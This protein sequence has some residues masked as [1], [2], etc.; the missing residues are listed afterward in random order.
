M[1]FLVFVVLRDNFLTI[2]QC[3]SFVNYFFHFFELFVVSVISISFPPFLSLQQLLV[4][5]SLATARLDY[6][7]SPSLVKHYFIFVIRN[8]RRS[9]RF[10]SY[11]YHFKMSTPFYVL[12]W[13]QFCHTIHTIKRRF[14]KQISFFYYIISIVLHLVLS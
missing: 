6:H 14:A 9:Q 3:F 7:N 1:F 13:I 2:S 11:H 8:F 5:C 4:L 10:V 12:I